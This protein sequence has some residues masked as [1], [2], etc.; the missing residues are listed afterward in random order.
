[1]YT[2]LVHIGTSKRLDLKSHPWHIRARFYVRSRL[3]LELFTRVRF[4]KP[5]SAGSRVGY[6]TECL[7]IAASESTRLAA[8]LEQ[9]RA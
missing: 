4:P 2:G 8:D 5:R 3:M 7:A 6:R 1:M 9:S